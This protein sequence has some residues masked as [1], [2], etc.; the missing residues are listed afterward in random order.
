MSGRLR[1]D[2]CTVSLTGAPVQRLIVDL[3]KPGSPLKQ[4]EPRCDYLFVA[5]SDGNVGWF[6]PLE[7]KRGNLLAG[8]VVEQLQAGAAVAEQHIADDNSVRFRPTAAF[9]SIHKYQRN[10]LRTN[11]S[12][13]HFH[14]QVEAIRLIKCGAPLSEALTV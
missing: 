10:K 12:K 11:V 4:N 5:N 13:I 7:L 2:G 3:D 6:E 1:K 14:N 8:K 9:G